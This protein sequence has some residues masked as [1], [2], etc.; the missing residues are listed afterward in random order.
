MSNGHNRLSLAWVYVK[1]KT[2][3]SEDFNW[4]SQHDRAAPMKLLHT[5]LNDPL[6][7]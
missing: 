7:M 5:K 1:S 3:M 4:I 2:R 6:D